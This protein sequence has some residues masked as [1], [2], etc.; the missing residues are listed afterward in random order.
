MSQEVTVFPSAAPFTVNVPVGATARDLKDAIAGRIRLL[1]AGNAVLGDD[2]ALTK[3]HQVSSTGSI[4]MSMLTSHEAVAYA[5]ECAKHETGRETGQ[6][7]R[8]KDT[9]RQKS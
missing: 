8:Q 7:T 2:V 9:F 4:F 5:A 3:V 1:T 6:E